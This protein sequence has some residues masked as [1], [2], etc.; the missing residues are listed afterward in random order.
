MSERPEYYT[1][2]GDIDVIDL[3]FSVDPEGAAGF[4]RWNIVKYATRAGKKGAE[5]LDADLDKVVSYAERMRVELRKRAE[6][7]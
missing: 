7:Q 2:G 3:A 1:G 5:T 6:G 4:C